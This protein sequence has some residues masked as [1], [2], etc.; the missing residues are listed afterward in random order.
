MPLPM[1]DPKSPKTHQPPAHY[2]ALFEQMNEGVALC[3][4][5]LGPNQTPV[6]YRILDVNPAYEAQTG[7][8]RSQV[9]GKLATLAYATGSPPLLEQLA[10]VT[11]SGL[12]TTFEMRLAGTGL[13]VSIS[14]TSIGGAVVATV[15]TDITQIKLQELE[16]SKNASAMRTMMENQPYLA[17]L[18]DKEGR[19]LAGNR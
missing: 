17:W 2:L 3:E 7:V 19:F 5:I 12:P 15:L 13:Y 9:V 18:K 4:V 1:D 14:V 10:S 6:D 16:L 8:V 11:V